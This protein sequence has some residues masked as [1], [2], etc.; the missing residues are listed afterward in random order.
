MLLMEWDTEEAKKVWFEEGLEEGMEKGREEIALNALAEGVPIE[1][2]KKISGFDEE[3]LKNI[4]AR[5]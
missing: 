5:L 1:L 4:Q 2:I 3:A